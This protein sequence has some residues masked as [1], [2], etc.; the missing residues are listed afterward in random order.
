MRDRGITRPE[1]K[2]AIAAILAIC[3]AAAV[4]WSVHFTPIGQEPVQAARVAKALGIFALI[5]GSLAT[6]NFL[7]ALSIVRKMRRGD[8][9]IGRWILARSGFEKFRES[10]RALKKRKNNWRMP[11]QDWPEGLPVIFSDNAVLVGNTYFKLLGGGISRYTYVRI[12]EASVPFIEFSMTL[13]A[14]GAGTQSRTARY[15]GHLRIP[16][17]D[18]ARVEAA[19]VVGHFRSVISQH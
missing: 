17:A 1:S 10:E 8:R 9:V 3:G 5:V 7:Y 6:L 16:V 15:R 19:N 11:R 14:Y 4:I 2:A 12:E 18:G 13:T